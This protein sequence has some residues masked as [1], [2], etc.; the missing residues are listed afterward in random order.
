MVLV[1]A[2]ADTGAAF[3]ALTTAGTPVLVQKTKINNY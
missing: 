3:G 1:V 2:G